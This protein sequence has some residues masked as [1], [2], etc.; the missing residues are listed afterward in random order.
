M[1][2][3]FTINLEF[4]SETKVLVNEIKEIINDNSNESSILKQTL[5]E[6]ELEE[7]NLV[8]FGD[9]EDTWRHPYQEEVVQKLKEIQQKFDGYF[10]GDFEWLFFEDDS[11]VKYNFSKDGRI[12]K[13]SIE[14]YEKEME[15][16]EANLS[17]TESDVEVK[18]QNL[19][20]F[21][22]L[23]D[24][25][26]GYNEKKGNQDD[27]HQL[28]KNQIF[29]GD[30][31]EMSGNFGAGCDLY[32]KLQEGIDTFDAAFDR[33]EKILDSFSF[34]SDVINDFIELCIEMYL[35]TDNYDNGTTSGKLIFSGDELDEKGNLNDKHPNYS[36]LVFFKYLNIGFKGN[37]VLKIIQKKIIDQNKKGI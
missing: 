10:V 2:Y 18:R 5:L 31:N 13:E 35:F 28:L 6:E 32:D 23:L 4:V 34:P 16:K 36:K 30:W 15:K 26:L 21:S 1:A 33:F 37:S 27:F 3:G 29:N 8:F 24:S 19:I 11:A 7:G 12:T 9:N 17:K 22:L 20:S 14:D 25:F